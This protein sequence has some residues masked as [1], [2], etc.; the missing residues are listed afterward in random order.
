M[1]F[2]TRLASRRCGRSR[3]STESRASSTSLPAG[4][5]C[6]TPLSSR[7][8]AGVAASTLS[9]ALAG[10]AGAGGSLAQAASRAA[11]RSGRTGRMRASY[12]CARAL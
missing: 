9:G 5:S 3:E 12:L 11:R 4:A 7:M 6:S 10:L 8:W 1:P 2:S